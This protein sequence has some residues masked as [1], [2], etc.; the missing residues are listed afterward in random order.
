[1]FSCS[2]PRL[3]G[4]TSAQGDARNHGKHK[5]CAYDL[6][7]LHK[8]LGIN[9]VAGDIAHLSPEVVFAYSNTTF[10]QV[11]TC[12]HP[13]RLFYICTLA[14]ASAQFSRGVKCASSLG[15][16]R[17]WWSPAETWEG[18]REGRILNRSHMCVQIVKREFYSGGCSRLACA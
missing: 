14:R 16:T 12:L 17:K 15:V 1:M 4:Q 9:A 3:F 6:I 7:F 18:N 5:V 2:P 13:P 8:S 10:A 11:G